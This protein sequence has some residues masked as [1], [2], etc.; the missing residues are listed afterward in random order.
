MDQVGGKGSILPLRAN[1]L[2]FNRKSDGI[3]SCGYKISNALLN[4]TLNVQY[5]GG[6][7]G[8]KGSD[9]ATYL[10]KRDKPSEYDVKTAK[11]MEDLIVPSGLYYCHPI[12]KH[13]V[14]HYVDAKDAKDGKHAKGTKNAKGNKSDDEGDNGGDNGVDNDDFIDE[15]LYD[16]LLE[17]VSPDSR[18]KYD[19]KTRKVHGVPYKLKVAKPGETGEAGDNTKIKLKN[20]KTKRVRFE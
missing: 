3:V 9:T 4:S 10:N 7:G 8:G 19:K 16:R 15:S 2:V 12:S 18:R 5:G 1:D 11:L 13:K 20:N 6:I 17:L 14:F